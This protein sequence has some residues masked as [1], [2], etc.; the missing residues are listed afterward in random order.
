MTAGGWCLVYDG[1]WM[2]VVVVEGGWW[3]VDLWARW[4]MV[5]GGWWRV[6]DGCWTG[7]LVV[8]PIWTSLARHAFCTNNPNL[9]D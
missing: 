6:D 9:F 8:R 3:M 1:F 4:W 7:G 5:D 2:V